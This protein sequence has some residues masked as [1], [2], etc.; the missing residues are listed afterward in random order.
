MA[1]V[2]HFSRETSTFRCVRDALAGV[3][4]VAAARSWEWLT[5]ALRERPV[6]VCVVDLAS[7]EL[8]DGGLEELLALRRRFPSVA[9]VLLERGSLDP[10]RLLDLGRLG[11]RS[12]VLMGY[13]GR[14]LGLRRK[15]ERAREETVASKVLRAVS[16]RG[17]GAERGARSCA[18]V[19][20]G[21][22]PGG[23]CGPLATL[24]Q[25]SAETRR[26]TFRREAIG[27]DTTA[28]RGGVVGRSGS[29]GAER[30]PAARVLVRSRV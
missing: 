20:V 16:A 9:F 17:E 1:L 12:L 28:S 30:E 5:V 29:H 27:L 18:P 19:L 13:E 3:H 23:A 14:A 15:I 22:L 4:D 11:F 6:S 10:R 25:L 24:S 2:Y 7:I 21:R 8:A 26:A